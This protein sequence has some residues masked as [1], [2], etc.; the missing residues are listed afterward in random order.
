MPTNNAQRSSISYEIRGY[1]RVR[2]NLRAVIAAHPQDT[3]VIM[4][5]WAQDTRMFLKRTPYPAKP[6]NSRY[7]RT[8]RLASSWAAKR[9][10]P[11][12]WGITNN[13]RSKYGVNYARYVVGDW[14][15][16]AHKANKWWRADKVIE[17]THIPELRLYLEEM[18]TKMWNE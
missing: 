5:R 17:Q 3:D 18:Y 2:N 10:K 9:I 4:Q 7:V 6:S 15:T 8:G 1:D 11:G 16:A 14:Q 13:A 12:V